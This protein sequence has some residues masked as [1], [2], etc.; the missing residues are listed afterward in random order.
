MKQPERYHRM[1]DDDGEIGFGYFLKAV[2][3]ALCVIGAAA[4]ALC[5]LVPF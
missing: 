2:T 4:V 5:V 1:T 3:M